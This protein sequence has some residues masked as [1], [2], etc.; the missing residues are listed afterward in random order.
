MAGP[1]MARVRLTVK[2]F[3]QKSAMRSA[4]GCSV[5]MACRVRGR[6]RDRKR[7]CRAVAPSRA[8]FGPSIAARCISAKT[9]SDARPPAMP[10]AARLSI[11]VATQPRGSP[12][13][14]SASPGIAPSPNR[15]SAMNVATS[16][17]YRFSRQ[18]N[19]LY[20]V[21]RLSSLFCYA[22]RPILADLTCG[23]MCDRIPAI[24]TIYGCSWA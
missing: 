24:L 21:Q 13:M 23:D 20:D 7:C 15:L 4:N 8:L 11:C 10:G 12:P 6:F 9:P 5:A 18:I 17:M 22:Y 19:S 14:A 2:W 16:R 3:D 1:T